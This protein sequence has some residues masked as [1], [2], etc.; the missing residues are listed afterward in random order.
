MMALGRMLQAYRQKEWEG[1]EG[2]HD[3]EGSELADQ[4]D[5]KKDVELLLNRNRR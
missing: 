2:D 1:S 3:A 4:D 5:D